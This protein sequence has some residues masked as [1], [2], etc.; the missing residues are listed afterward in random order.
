[1]IDPKSSAATASP[2]LKTG[3][4]IARDKA[5]PAA[6]RRYL[7]LDDFER[8]GRRH[9]P[10]ML[11]GFVDGGTETE[12]A[13]RGNRAS[14]AAHSLVPRVLVDTHDRSCT[15]TLFNRVYAAPFGI[16]PM[17]ITALCAYRGDLALSAAAASADIP[18]ILSASSLIPMEAVRKTGTH[19]FQAYLPGDQPRID[20]LVDR[21][22]RA[23]FETLVVTVD[24]PVPANRENNARNGFSVPLEPS[25]RLALDGMTHPS[26][27]FGT[28]LRTLL[29]H[30]MPHFENMDAGRGPPILARDVVRAVGPRDRLTWEHLAA[31]R[32]RWTGSMVIKG[33]LS[34]AD[35]IIARETGIDG[36]IISNHGGRQLDAAVAPLIALPSIAAAVPGMTIMLDGGV[37]R[38]TDVLKALALGAHFVFVG[39]PF[40]YAAAVGGEALVHHA[41][42]LLTE[43][44]RRNMALL[45]IRRL[46]ELSH[47]HLAAAARSMDR[48]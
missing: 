6:V 43:E 4:V 37:R 1:M 16:A 25:I 44:I 41:A 15:T 3:H 31:I 38:G 36:I 30:G 9:L 21:V 26:W 27:L 40:L 34:A 20:A 2:I 19:W 28:A 12:A 47:A 17:G 42:K 8:A 24:I 23:G 48:N 5:K 39:R 13:L 45:G 14:F 46:S 18:M 32:K 35:A 22:A 7:S 33:V 29:Q 11:S 10:A